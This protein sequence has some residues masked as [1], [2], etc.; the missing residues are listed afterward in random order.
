MIIKINDSK[1]V[2]SSKDALLEIA[3]AKFPVKIE[4][5]DKSYIFNDFMTAEHFFEYVIKKEGEK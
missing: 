2:N 5:E 4:I 1:C 3:F